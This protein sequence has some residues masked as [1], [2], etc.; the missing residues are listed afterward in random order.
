MCIRDRYKTLE[1]NLTFTVQLADDLPEVILGDPHRLTQILANLLGNAL[2]FTQKGE[3]KLSVEKIKQ[4]NKSIS[5]RFK[6]YDTG[7]GI[8][9]EKQ[10]TIFNRFEQ[11][12]AE[13]T[14]RFGG[15]GLGLTITK[16]L[17]DLQN[18]LI[19]VQSIEGKETTFIIEI[20][21]E[22]MNANEIE[23]K[24]QKH[25]KDLHKYR[26]FDKSRETGVNEK[27]KSTLPLVA[28]ASPFSLTTGFVKE[29]KYKNTKILVAEDNRMNRRILELIFEDW[30]FKVDF[31][32]NGKIALDLLEEHSYDLILMDLQMP[33]MDG[34]TATQIIREELNI[35]IPIIAITA[36]AFAGEREKCIQHGMNDYLS[37]PIDVD[38]L[39]TMILHYSPNKFKAD[40]AIKPDSSE[41]IDSYD[42]AYLN[43]ITRGDK[44]LLKEF[45]SM[46]IEQSTEEIEE[47]E[48]A[49]AANNFIELARA[50]HSMKNTILSMGFKQQFQEL[51]TAIEIETKK[52][53]PDISTLTKLL[54]KTKYFQIQA[55]D[56]LA[57]KYL[58]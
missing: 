10:E 37:K 58:L 55:I 33:E 31:A 2:K 50:A 20:P 30:G 29:R 38:K 53:I 9:I 3:V 24:E 44:K 6:V 35:S 28:F 17:V 25:H 45:T 15:S 8:P 5:I 36:H 18:G 41:F 14:R 16:Q 12:T 49:L 34:Y 23:V 26:F 47:M 19:K 57:K 1:K 52:E 32:E 56:F 42:G 21:Y 22:L 11:A 46:V 39:A 43:A 40:R 54:H 51:L 7:V 13:S 27:E 48:K 4:E